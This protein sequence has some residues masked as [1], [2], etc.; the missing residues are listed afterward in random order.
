MKYRIFATSRSG[1]HAFINWMHHQ[2]SESTIHH[3]NC[4]FGWNEGKFLPHNNRSIAYGQAPFK[5]EIY[6]IEYM[7]LNDYN[8]YQ[9]GD[10]KEYMDILFLRDFPNWLAS[11]F[12][13]KDSRITSQWNNL[14]NEIQESLVD[15][16][17][18]YAKEFSGQT[19]LINNKVR[20]S[21]NE[22]FSSEDYRKAIC[23]KLNLDYKSG[24]MEK[25]STFC[26]GSSYSGTNIKNGTKLLVTERWKN[27]INDNEYLKALKFNSENLQLNKIIFNINL[28]D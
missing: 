13:I 25:I 11:T 6:S 5:H 17:N 23:N 9:M 3:N 26:G 24:G 7:D 15:M 1:H 4:L 16:W 10:Q 27:H 19:S 2:L 14:K 22:Y 8:K 18:Q 12:K 20:I 28:P 21:Y